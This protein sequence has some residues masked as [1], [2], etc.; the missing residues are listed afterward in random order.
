LLN[1]SRFTTRK[2]VTLS[3][4][5]VS[6]GH[7]DF[8]VSRSELGATGTK[9][10]ST[11]LKDPAGNSALGAKLSFAYDNATPTGGTLNGGTAHVT[12]TSGSVTVKSAEA[13][14]AY[15]IRTSGGT[16]GAAMYNNLTGAWSD[17]NAGFNTNSW[18]RVAINQAN[19][20]TGMS[21]A[22]LATGGY[23][24][25]V[26][27]SAGNINNAP[28]TQVDVNTAVTL[29]AVNGNDILTASNLGSISGKARTQNSLDTGTNAIQIVFGTTTKTVTPAAGGDWRYNL[30][31]ADIV[32]LGQGVQTITVRHLLN[33]NVVSTTSRSVLVDSQGP[34]ATA[35]ITAVTDD[36]GASTGPVSSGGVTDDTRLVL[37]GSVTGTLATGDTV[38]VFDGVSFLGN[39]V[40]TGSTW[41]FSDPRALIDN[42]AV[43]YNVRVSDSSGNL[44]T[45]SAT[46]NV[47]VDIP[48]A[49]AGVVTTPIAYDAAMLQSLQGFMVGT[50]G[51]NTTTKGLGG[52]ANGGAE[53]WVM[54]GTELM[55]LH[56]FVA[57]NNTT[58][59]TTFVANQAL[60]LEFL[61]VG[62]G[63][64]G[65]FANAL[66]SGAGGGGQMKT[67]ALG[68]S[69]G[70]YTVVVGAGGAAPGFSGNNG[71]NGVSSRFAA[72][73]AMGG[74]GGG[75]ANGNNALQRDGQTAGTEGGSAGAV[76]E[77]GEGAGSKAL[78][79]LGG[80][81]AASDISGE[82][83]LYG[84][85]GFGAQFAAFTD[86]LAPANGG[87]GRGGNAATSVGNGVD[88]L[89]GGGGGV[90]S[91]GA[92]AGG[93]GGSGVVMARYDVLAN[94]NELLNWLQAIETNSGNTDLLVAKDLAKYLNQ[95]ETAAH[96]A[97]NAWQWT[98]E[99]IAAAV[100]I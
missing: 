42:Q 79:R 94:E 80:V 81:G 74:G 88:N 85:G 72:I 67:G 9:V 27:D 34:T 53:S 100:V 82:S 10:L 51:F 25:F 19:T 63:G 73:E 26:V 41:T 11:E 31:D 18:T 54:A 84:G 83:V 6:S 98:P 43:R 23:H 93:R 56:E 65:G 13:G 64:S 66:T 35:S 59:T 28:Q 3:N 14:T 87:G 95:I 49:T 70:S 55:R 69:D 15:L 78:G 76:S 16:S 36:V 38:R 47:T 61:A 96:V 4:D 77:G 20:N 2:L 44:G 1:G 17:I 60:N 32:A 99:Q 21:V 68:L 58:L 39:A 12:G 7:V 8:N 90:N 45:A 37:S 62:G 71:N 46:H 29:Y 92:A 86:T 75:A 57:S 91:G 48:V 33:G 52:W 5:N 24:L 97:G 40:V 22:G 30:Q 50:G 89:G